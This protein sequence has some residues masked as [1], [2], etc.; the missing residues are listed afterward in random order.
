LPS[1]NRTQERGGIP[2]ASLHRLARINRLGGIDADQAD[3]DRLAVEAD[4]DGIAIDDAPDAEP[5]P[6]QLGLVDDQ[7]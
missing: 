2:G 4:H 7:G 3:L 6:R 5:A 1:T